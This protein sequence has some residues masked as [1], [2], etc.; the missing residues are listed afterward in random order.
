MQTLRQELAKCEPQ[1]A[2]EIYHLWGMDGLSEKERKKREDILLKHVKEPVAARFVWEYL[3]PDERQILY[4]IVGTSA[5]S[6]ARRD[7]T[8][9]KSLLSEKRFE[10]VVA[11]LERHLLLWE[12][13]V[14]IRSER[15]NSASRRMITTV[16]D[17]DLLHPYMESA[18]ALYQAGKELFSEKSDRSQMTL[19]KILTSFYHGDLNVAARH[20]DIQQNYYH[21][22]SNAEL[23]TAIK[24]EL[25]LPEGA[26]E[27]LQQ[28]DPS[29]HTLFKWLCEQGG[30]VSIKALRKH[31]GYADAA[32]FNALHT[33]EEFAI[34][35]DTF[36][37]G[38]RVLFVPADVFENLKKAVTL[39]LPEPSHAGLVQPGEPPQA[40]REG[41]TPLLYDLASVV[42]SIYQQAIEPTQAGK[43]PK[44][45]ASKI[46]PLMHGKPRIRYM[47]EGDEYMEMVFHI[48]E[49]LGIIH[50]SRPALEGIKPRYEPGPALE[51]WSKLDMVEQARRVLQCWTK[52]FRWIDI[53][54]VNFRQTDP[55]YWNPVAGRGAIL[56]FL[57]ECVPGQ[58]YTVSSLLDTIWDK[59]PNV[60]RP[61]QYRMP[62]SERRKSASMHVKWNSC[63]GE[64]FTGLLN[65]SLYEMGIVA[66]GYQQPE[67]PNADHP[68]NPDAFMI[69]ELGAAVLSS[70]KAS[71]A[72]HS[73]EGGKRSLV[74]QP[75][76]ELLLLHP[77][78]PTLY[79]LLPF[80]QINQ[81][82]IVS[83]LTLSRNSVLR[84]V[85]AGHD[86][87][88][89]LKVLEEH[90]QKEIPQNVAYTLRDWVKAYRDTRIS[91]VF[92]LE[93]SSEAIA[94]EV[95]ASPKMQRFG[96]RKLAP[97]VLV[98]NNSVNLQ[99]L[100]HA[101]EKEGIVVRVS[102][103]I[104][105]RQN[106]YEI[107]TAGR[108]R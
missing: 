8:L 20:Y 105:T 5:R 36:S 89:I 57:K 22:Y 34:A 11:S 55:Y 46:Q 42:G 52:S 50:V 32:L 1:Q 30:R 69:T 97:R 21:Y 3:S 9:K 73:Q 100:R 28:L 37:Q 23:R 33:F 51:Q 91:Q 76:F 40:I 66:L 25:M 108:L 79:S 93:V 68:K 4:R 98:A 74:L 82:D 58:W 94:D 39:A 29:L 65:S 16:E 26:F 95:C 78:M 99:E 54:G 84:G 12:D 14:K 44:R 90:S 102:D 62:S 101:L 7:I 103:D 31:T 10:A 96:L 72:V 15:Y 56:E 18:D 43:V 88:E 87:E 83:R 67:L 49:E 63:E 38:E 71:H 106:R 75:N 60:L 59:N 70:D 17:V 86:V 48:A 6:G 45:I 81:M 24:D 107:A 41:A 13:T 64:L 53:L 61:T 77:D 35:F 104:I 2:E 92:L 19:D 80:A 47:N 27:I 85:E